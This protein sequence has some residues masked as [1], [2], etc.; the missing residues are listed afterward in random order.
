M[1]RQRQ[2]YSWLFKLAAKALKYF[3]L[4]MAGCTV[5]Y[6]LAAVLSFGGIVSLMV[7]LLEALALRALVVVFCLGA[8]AV[9]AESLR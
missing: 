8:I 5:T 7:W 1:M 2:P 9:I 4:G 3:L 6:V